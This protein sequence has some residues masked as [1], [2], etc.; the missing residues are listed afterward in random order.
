MFLSQKEKILKLLL[1]GKTVHMRK[2]NNVAFR[3]GARLSD[4]RKDGYKIKTI[5]NGCGNFSYRLDQ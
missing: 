1:G 2:L 5:Q 3:Y 4:L